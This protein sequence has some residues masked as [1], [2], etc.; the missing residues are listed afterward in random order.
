MFRDI[1]LL[2]EKG[3]ELTEPFSKPMENGIYELRTCF[4]NNIVRVFYFFFYG[5]KIVL[6]NGYIKKTNK[7]PPGELKK[8]IKYKC[9]YE[10]RCGK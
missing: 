10:R 4:G 7:T 1:D 2:E 5:N 3:F 6:T 9:D 8:A